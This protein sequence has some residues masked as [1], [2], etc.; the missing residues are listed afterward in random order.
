MFIASILSKGKSEAVG[1]VCTV[2]LSLRR[3][4]DVRAG[5]CLRAYRLI[6]VQAVKTLSNGSPIKSRLLVYQSSFG[7]VLFQSAV[8]LTTDNIDTNTPC[9]QLQ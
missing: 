4:I 2:D 7:F 3:L 6:Y 1:L 9:K 8:V 5:K